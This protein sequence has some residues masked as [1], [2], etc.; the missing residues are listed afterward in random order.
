MVAE[1]FPSFGALDK[2]DAVDALRRV[3]T[4]IICGTE[5]KLTSIGHSRKLHAQHRRLDRCSSATAPA[6]W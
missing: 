4:T 1:F 5:D 6:T 3:P 2:F